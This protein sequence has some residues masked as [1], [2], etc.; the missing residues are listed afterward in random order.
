MKKRKT[1][2]FQVALGQ[3][4]LLVS[5]ILIALLLGLVPDRNAAIRSGRAAFAESLALN[6]SG[7]LA[8][9]DIR[10]M[11]S[12]L[13][14]VVDRNHDLISAGI[15]RKDG[16]LIAIGPHDGEWIPMSG[17]YSSD[18][19]VLVP[20][21]SSDQQWGQ[22]ELRFASGAYF[23]DSAQLQSVPLLIFLGAS[24]FV[25]FY[26]YLGKMLQHL[27][28]S[29][30]IPQRVRS[31]LDTM[32][33]GLLVIDRQGQ[34]VLANE[35]IAS[36]LGKDVDELLGC[37]AHDFAWELDVVEAFVTDVPPWTKCL[38]S[39]VPQRNAVIHLPGETENDPAR[40]FIV[41]CSPVMAAGG[42]QGGAL[43]SFDDVTQLE[44]KKKELGIA[45]E[46]AEAANQSKSEFLANMSHEIRTPMNAILGFTDVLRRGYGDSQEDPRQY[47]NTIHSSGTHLLELINDILDLSKVES[48]RMDVERIN[49]SPYSIVR[50]VIQVLSVKAEEKG[51]ALEFS[52]NGPIP[53]TIES[54]PSRL[55]QIITNLVGN[56][57]KFTEEGGVKVVMRLMDEG[58]N[59]GV[60]LFCIDIHDSGIGMS[61]DQ[62]DRIFDPFSQADSS[63]TR[64]FGGTGLGLTISRR[65][66][67][68][69][70]GAVTVSSEADKGS[71]FSVTIDP[72]NLAG[73]G[74]LTRDELEAISDTGSVEEHTWA[75]HDKHVLVV[76]DGPENRALVSLVLRESGIQVTCAED[77]K[78][79]VDLA[80]KNQFDMILMDMQMP[81]MDGYTAT[82]LLRDR[83]LTIP[84]YALTAHAM[85]GFENECLAAGCSG[86]LTK[87]ID[88]DLLLE[89]LGDLLG[90]E[91][92]AKPTSPPEA[93]ELPERKAGTTEGK[94]QVEGLRTEIEKLTN[95]LTDALGVMNEALADEDFALLADRARWLKHAGESIGLFELAE[96]AQRLEAAAMTSDEVESATV[97][98]ELES[99]VNQLQE[100]D[101][102]CVEPP[103]NVSHERIVSQL[104]MDDPD[105]REIVSSFV[106]RLI[107]KLDDM[108]DALRQCDFH[109]LAELSH[110]LKGAGGTVGFPQF[111]EPAASLERQARK[112]NADG[113]APEL[114]GELKSL[115]S[116]IHIPELQVADAAV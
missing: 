90:G 49:C 88:I 48:G 84:I 98:A 61:Q 68:A 31:A 80:T 47:L 93:R 30:A 62:M 108:D 97:L 42:K 92:V 12:D 95:R 57:I 110:W 86:F 69:L 34:I 7:H 6:V 56:A 55:R 26:L 111:T 8:R 82:T 71:V 22:L 9:S 79:A 10:Q 72:G 89:T 46:A 116:R 63:V 3:T 37:K 106:P 75:F 11:R 60:P 35:S 114:L 104:P 13:V 115:A 94:S 112:E 16:R 38:E 73:I 76:D 67:E 91:K 59:K 25:V 53:R 5:L 28:P 43:I 107:Q 54:D 19:Q 14:L 70:G 50:D 15:R 58:V 77:G 27:D 101:G 105:F 87:P 23:A 4:G 39:G 66:G 24:G 36:I 113:T 40:T 2:K 78:I 44:E 81:V 20:L 41:N 51:I 65:F 103:T 17:T 109:E 99:L 74:M 29:R 96:P 64:R 102:D 33:E 85:K 18:V 1:A 83:G 52:T 45:K 32:A 100:T 21:F